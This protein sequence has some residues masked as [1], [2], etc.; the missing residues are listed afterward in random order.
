MILKTFEP[1]RMKKLVISDSDRDFT[2][3]EI[4]GLAYKLDAVFFEETI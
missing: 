3:L 1:L 2:T 4:K